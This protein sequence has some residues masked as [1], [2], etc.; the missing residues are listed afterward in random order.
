MASTIEWLNKINQ[1]LKDRELIQKYVIKKEGVIRDI[2]E[3]DEITDPELRLRVQRLREIY[4]SINTPKEEYSNTSVIP[5]WIKTQPFAVVVRYLIVLCCHAIIC[6]SIVNKS[7]PSVIILLSLIGFVF[8]LSSQETV[9]LVKSK[10]F[11][12][13][14]DKILL[15]NELTVVVLSVAYYYTKEVPYCAHYILL[16][17]FFSYIEDMPSFPKRLFKYVLLF[18]ILIQTYL[19]VRSGFSDVVTLPIKIAVIWAYFLLKLAVF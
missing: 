16:M 11:N 19:Y 6:Y 13:L 18:F 4:S 3:A 9:Y 10:S 14:F 8:A 5:P 2:D 15:M 7:E 17:I 1:A 12:I